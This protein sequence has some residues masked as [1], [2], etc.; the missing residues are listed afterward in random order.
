MPGRLL[1]ACSEAPSTSC[2]SKPPN[3]AISTIEQTRNIYFVL[4]EKRFDFKI[5]F[6]SVSSRISACN[7][8][9][10]ACTSVSALGVKSWEC[11]LIVERRVHVGRSPHRPQTPVAQC[12]PRSD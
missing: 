7:R 8:W 11:S 6:A 3:A 4:F 9:I 1:F 12:R 2:A 10:S 5:S